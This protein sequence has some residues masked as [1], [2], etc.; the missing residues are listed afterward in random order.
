MEEKRKKYTNLLA[1]DDKIIS[2]LVKLRL[3]SEGFKVIHFENGEGVY[4]EA[5]RVKP[6]LILLDNM[7][8]VKDGLTVLKELKENPQISKIPVIFLT[9]S[10]DEDSV[11]KSIEGGAADYILKPYTNEDLLLRIRR[12]LTE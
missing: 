12:Q 10:S 11:R 4:Q 6:D 9:S 3:S 1:E 8:P 5:Q 7:M 2:R